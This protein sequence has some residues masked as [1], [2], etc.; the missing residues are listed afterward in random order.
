MTS[1][2]VTGTDL[3]AGTIS[4]EYNRDL[5]FPQSVEIYDEMRKSDATVIAVLRA[6]K[7]P[8]L[9]AKW[10]IQPGG[11]D[12]KDKEIAEFI[13]RNLFKKVKFRNFLRESL[14]FLDF[15]FYYFEKN[16][17]IV[18]GMVEWKEF[19]PRLPK[20]HYLWDIA[21]TPWID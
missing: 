1:H 13:T 21:K 7:Q 16:F 5:I 20:A 12:D 11:E 10:T 17:E 6:I 8:I 2:G 14:G 18:N 19:A 4:E 3:Q 15:G 9:S